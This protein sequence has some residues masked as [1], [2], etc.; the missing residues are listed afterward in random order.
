MTI[1]DIFV[2]LAPRTHFDAQLDAAARLAQA[3][4][5]TVNVVF[6][7]EAMM[8]TANVPEM[9]VAAGV[10]VDAI[11]HETKLAETSAI[12]QFEQWRIAHGLTGTSQGRPGADAT[13]HERIGAIADTVA[14]IGRVSDLVIIG[15]PAPDETVTDEIFK[16]AIYLTGC[17]TLLVP[18]RSTA[19]PLEHVLIAWNG[20]VEAARAV[21]GA[22]PMLKAA[23][24]V[25]IFTVPGNPEALYHHLGLIEHLEHHGVRAGWVEPRSSSSHVGLLLAETASDEKASMIV[26]GAYTHRRV[27]QLLLGGVTQ[28]MVKHTEIAVLMMH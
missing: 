24:R 20:S 25:S 19:D 1:R 27:Q 16:S 4:D 18:N 12:T 2:P 13:W 21:A 26:M 5:A 22:M 17:P 3:F 7:R 9:L 14:E 8:T 11:E 23:R 28:H 6:T 10:V 15:K